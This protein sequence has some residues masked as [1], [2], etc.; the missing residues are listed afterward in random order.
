MTITYK[1]IEFLF[2]SRPQTNP[3]E[4]LL[5]SIGAGDG[6]RNEA[7]PFEMMLRSDEITDFFDSPLME[8]GITNNS[9]LGNIL[10]LKLELWLD[11]TNHTALLF[12]YGKN[13]GQDFRK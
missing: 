13:G 5:V 7:T 10:P 12:Q 6:R 2:T 11:Q 8:S 3:S 4:K 9:A 1:V